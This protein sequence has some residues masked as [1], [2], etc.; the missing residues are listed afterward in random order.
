MTDSAVRLQALD[1][2]H[3]FI[4]QAPAGSGKT[5]LLTQ[6]I[7]ALLATVQ[8]IPEE[9]LAVTF[10]RKAAAEMRA[11]LLLALN[12]A[13]NSE[14]PEAPFARR[15]WD[16]A[17]KVLARDRA[18]G[19]DLLENPQRFA[20]MTIDA[21]AMY[22]VAQLPMLSRFGTAP[23]IHDDARQCYQTAVQRLCFQSHDDAAIHTLWLHCDNRLDTVE[24]LL[25]DLLACRDQWLPYMVGMRTGRVLRAALEGALERIVQNHLAHLQSIW[26]IPFAEIQPLCVFAAA[27]LEGVVDLDWQIEAFTLEHWQFV[28]EMM[29]TKDDTWRKQLTKREGFPVGA[30]AAEKKLFKY[31]KSAMLAILESCASDEECRIALSQVRVLPTKHYTEKS[32]RVIEALTH[33]LPNLV[34]ELMVVFKETGAVDYLAVS[35]AALTAMGESDLPTDLALKLDYKIQHLLV[36]EF[37]DTSYLQL[38]LFERLVSGWT[39]G[40][41]KTVFLVGDPMQS[42]YRFRGAE[43]GLFLKVQ[44]QG[45]ANIPLTALCLS[46]NFRSAP[47]LIDWSN[48]TFGDIFPPYADMTRGAVPHSAAIASVPEA[49]DAALYFYTFEGTE[50]SPDTEAAGVVDLVC[51]HHL[52]HPTDTIAILVRSRR[53]AQG[54]LSVLRQ[55]QVE[56]QSYDM[57]PL[58]DKP[59]ILHLLHLTRALLFLND[60]IAWLALL[61][62]PYIGLNLSDLYAIGKPPLEEGIFTRLQSQCASLTSEGQARMALV[63]PVL[64]HWLQQRGRFSLREWIRGAWTAL[65]GDII[66]PPGA[67]PD[68]ACFFDKIAMVEQGGD[69]PNF[70]VLETQLQRAYSQTVVANKPWLELMTIHKAKGLEF[71]MVVIPGITEA[72]RASEWPLLTWY[73]RT[74]V[75]GTDWMVAAAPS[76]ERESDRIYQFIQAQEKDRAFFEQVRLLYVAT[77]RAKKQLVF[78]ATLVEGAPKS[79]NAFYALLSAHVLASPYKNKGVVAITPA[80]C[81]QKTPVGLQ[82]ISMQSQQKSIERV[83]FHLREKDNPFAWESTYQRALRIT[84]TVIHQLFESASVVPL[85]RW[86]DVALYAA[87][88]NNALLAAGVPRDYISEMCHKMVAAMQRILF[89]DVG[90]WIL[91]AREEA[92]SEWSLGEQG[93]TYIVDRT[94]VDQGVRWIID[95]KTTTE[96]ELTPA[97]RG[98]YRQQLEKYA[99]IVRAFDARPIKLGLYFPLRTLAW[100]VWDY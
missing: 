52:L 94:F 16:F 95:Y 18:Q 87:S 10:T 86:G 31:K 38:K 55:Q 6:R 33:I 64:S 35:L 54:I 45:L 50:E 98:Q 67:A 58:V 56:F 88:W 80:G 48:H 62:G 69:I 46:Q 97:I 76:A 72:P 1:T 51:A 22:L 81:K 42:I 83:S 27:H 92:A 44:A 53:Q 63:L 66:L 3:S 91:S 40:D 77:T 14:P 65:G 39:P 85:D 89:C 60:R 24:K 57:E 36:D 75:E 78:T 12:R 19:W 61:R 90:R 25:C 13:R 29:L 15:T 41:G 26:P 28:A 43:V 34:A 71:D 20:V 7:L 100:E 23:K 74:H 17:Q 8:S 47:M 59:W 93:E 84:G 68:V 82:R 70:A 37:Q 30:I 9:V 96:E 4:V 21:L 11:R 49:A 32:W 2:M 73:E 79:K 5:E 99:R